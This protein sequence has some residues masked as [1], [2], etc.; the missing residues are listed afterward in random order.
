MAVFVPM[1]RPLH[2]QLD[3]ETPVSTRWSKCC[4]ELVKLCKNHLVEGSLDAL[5]LG[6]GCN[7]LRRSRRERQSGF[8]LGPGSHG[9]KRINE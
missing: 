1:Y 3:L 2:I 4:W 9:V 5:G 7:I 8:R 6:F